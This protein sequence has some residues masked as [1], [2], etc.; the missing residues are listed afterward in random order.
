M[1][2]EDDRL[3]L[4]GLIGGVVGGDGDGRTMAWASTGIL[5]ESPEWERVASCMAEIRCDTVGRPGGGGGGGERGLVVCILMD[6]EGL[7][8]RCYLKSREASLLCGTSNLW[9]EN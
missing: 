4:G 6:D 7:Q 8:R 9:G 2:D 1:D 3:L 5:D